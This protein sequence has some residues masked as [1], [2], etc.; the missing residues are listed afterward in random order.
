MPREY[1]IYRIRVKSPTAEIY[2]DFNT[3]ARKSGLKKAFLKAIGI[4]F[5]D[6]A[7]DDPIKAEH[8]ATY[9]GCSAH[10]ENFDTTKKF[11]VANIS[12]RALEQI[13]DQYLDRQGITKVPR[14][15]LELEFTYFDNM[16]DS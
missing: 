1:Q 15:D 2:Y 13:P 10:R 8:V 11:V 16:L 14:A 6:F 5:K 12:V 4:A 3:N 7:K 9:Y